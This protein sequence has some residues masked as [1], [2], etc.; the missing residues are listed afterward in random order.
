M[1]RFGPDG[2]RWGSLDRLGQG[3][4]GNR[5]APGTDYSLPRC[6]ALMTSHPLCGISFGLAPSRHPKMAL[7]N[8]IQWH[9]E[10]GRYVV[11]SVRD[12]HDRGDLGLH[13]GVFRS[14]VED[15]AAGLVRELCSRRRRAGGRIAVAERAMRREQSASI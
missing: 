12:A 2:G 10:E 5:L 11:E 6:A 7:W 13:P 9:G 8:G 14:R 4:R 15:V 3:P 1:T